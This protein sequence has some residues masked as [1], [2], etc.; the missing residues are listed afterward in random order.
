MRIGLEDFGEVVREV[1]AGCVEG[2]G[3]AEGAFEG[4]G[5]F[6]LDAAGDD[7]VEEAEVGGDVEG[8]AVGGNPAAEVNAEGG[9]F[10]F[11]AIIGF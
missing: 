8:E 6:A 2:N 9:E 11:G 3:A 4:G 5:A 7:E 1:G 10:F